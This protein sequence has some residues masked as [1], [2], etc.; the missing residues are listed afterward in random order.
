MRA[1][2]PFSGVKRPK[3]E[4]VHS[5]LSSAEDKKGGSSDYTAS[6][7]WAGKTMEGLARGTTPAFL[8][9]DSPKT[10]HQSAYDPTEDAHEHG[11]DVKDED[12]PQNCWLSALCPSSGIL[13]T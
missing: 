12:S 2:E 8:R 11:N 5:V 4:A 3:R 6:S 9:A 10:T 13:N 1:W 7:Q